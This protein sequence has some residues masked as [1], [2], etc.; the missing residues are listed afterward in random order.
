[1][2]I[3]NRR[4]LKEEFIPSKLLPGEFAVATDTGNAWYCYSGGKVMLIATSEDIEKLRQEAQNAE[5]A[6]QLLLDEMRENIDKNMSVLRS[7]INLT[8]Q[9][10]IKMRD[11]VL[12]QMDNKLASVEGDII[13]AQNTIR[14]LA[15]SQTGLQLLLDGKID[16]AYVEDGYLYMTS[17]NE[18]VVGPLGPF[19]GGGGGGGGTGNNAVLTV[20]N[21]S[22]WLSK[23]VASGAACE[24]SVTWSSLEDDLPTGN[25]TLKVTI[26]GLVKTTQDIAQG[27]V[28]VDIGK[29][30]STGANMVKVNVADVYG[31]SR[32]INYSVSVVEVSVSST[33]D[34]GVPCTGAITYTYTPT[35]NVSKTMHFIVDG[36]EI[37]SGQAFL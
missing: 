19:S 9:D 8:K 28:T 34:A 27:K 21:T 13:D 29:Y 32:T 14:I 12:V 6:T 11:E 31:N 35:G 22:G 17:N 1:M 26:N 4:G 36:R 7:E 25:G 20:S 16:D 10:I 33:F 23:S 15:D 3:R 24:I 2:S 18:I 30:L 5:E 37:C